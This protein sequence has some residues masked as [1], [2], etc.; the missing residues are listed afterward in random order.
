MGLL[1][2]QQQQKRLSCHAL[3]TNTHKKKQERLRFKQQMLPRN[4]IEQKTLVNMPSI[5]T[6][7]QRVT[8]FPSRFV[9]PFSNENAIPLY[10]S[11]NFINPA[12]NNCLPCI[13]CGNIND[14]FNAIEEQASRFK[15]Y[16][17]NQFDKTNIVVGTV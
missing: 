12:E 14:R 15:N 1:Q 4:N 8:D 3:A 16:V 17:P 13:V 10:S 2:L 9:F 11:I 5:V 6:A 7:S